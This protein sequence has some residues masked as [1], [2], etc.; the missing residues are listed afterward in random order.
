MLIQVQVDLW[1]LQDGREGVK[2]EVREGIK[3]GSQK[4]KGKP[5]REN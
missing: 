5:M 1:V 4:W 2:D 3:Q